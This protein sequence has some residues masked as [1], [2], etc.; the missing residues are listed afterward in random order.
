[1]EW[2]RTLVRPTVTWAMTFIFGY[3]LLKGHIPWEAAVPIVTLVFVFW[4]EEKAI[5]R[6]IEKIT[7][8]GG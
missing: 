4:F 5:E 7:K 1:M 2:L 6:A 8:K 3:G